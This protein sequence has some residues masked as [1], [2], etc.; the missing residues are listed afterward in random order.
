MI[1]I[2]NNSCGSLR[3][4]MAPFVRR[5]L[6]CR[7]QSLL[8]TI[9]AS[10]WREQRP[11]DKEIW[12]PFITTSGLFE[13]AYLLYALPNKETASVCCLQLPSGHWILASCSNVYHMSCVLFGGNCSFSRV[14]I[15]IIVKKTLK[16]WVWVM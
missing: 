14:Q 6:K 9:T 16:A 5:H 2:R 8:S 4:W 13:L 7:V 15:D 11:E 3:C 12:F 1:S 10:G